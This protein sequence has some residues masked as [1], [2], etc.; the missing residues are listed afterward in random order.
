MDIYNSLYITKI[1]FF[2]IEYALIIFTLIAFICGIFEN[3]CYYSTSELVIKVL[4]IVCAA[5][6]LLY[7]ILIIVCL[8]FNRK[9]ILNFINK[10]NFD[11]E[12]RKIDYKWN[13]AVLIHSLFAL[14]YVIIFLAFADKFEF[15]K[16]TFNDVSASRNRTGTFSDI[17]IYNRHEKTD[18]EKK[19]I[20]DLE[21]KITGLNLVITNL[22]TKIVDITKERDILQKNNSENIKD[23]STLKYTLKDY[24][25]VDDIEKLR[26]IINEKDDEIAL[27]KENNKNLLEN[28]N[29][30]KTVA[31]ALKNS[32]NFEL[33][34]DEK[35]MFVIF[36]SS[37]QQVHYPIIC[38][39]N[40]KFNEVENLLYDKFPE[41]KEF[42]NYF[43]LYGKKISKSL[44][45]D[46]NKIKYGDIITMT[47][48]EEDVEK[49]D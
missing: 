13:V 22:N 39:N 4:L 37:D 25:E 2:C 9:Y 19:I 35:L 17:V 11:F 6:Y 23:Y 10:I 30:H 46:E 33:N 24:K 44:T 28:V 36:M 14:I 42:E 49:I 38:K 5:L 21:S 41:Y 48:Y 43:L 32:I 7:F 16:D 27:L 18:N 1:V 45:L 8:D 29:D 34:K 31:T 15:D 47:K 3:C 12:N 26:I 20:K 40:Q